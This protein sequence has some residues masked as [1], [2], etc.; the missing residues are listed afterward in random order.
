MGGKTSTSSQQVSVPPQVLAQYQAVNDRA[1]QTASTPFQQYGGE[2]VAPVNDQQNQ[3]IAGTNAAATEAQ[4]YY[5]AATGVLGQAQSDTTGVNQAAIG[6]TASSSSPLTGQQIGQYL[7][8][9]LKTVLGSESALLNQN[10]QQQQAGQLGNAI[11]SGAFGSDRTGIAAANLAQQQE[12]ANA[13]VY[14]G[15]L[16]TGYQSALG[17]AQG[18]QQIGLAGAQQL[19]GI[20]STAYG[21]GA[22]TASELGSLGTG[23]QT[24]GLT[25]AA[26]QIQAGTVQQQTQQAQDTALYN[27]F[28]QKQSYPFQVD[29]FLANI[30]EGTG[31]L[32]GSTTTTQQPG[33]FFSDERLKEDMEPVGKL[34]DGQTIYRYKLKGDS[35]DRIGLSAQETEKTHPEAVG[36]ARG[37]RWVDYGKA[38]DDAANR[39]H[40]YSGGVVGRAPLTERRALAYGG[41]SGGGLDSVLQAQQQMYSGLGARRQQVGGQG[42]G[43][44]QLAVAS[45]SPPPAASGSNTTQQVIGLGKDAYKAYQ[46]FNKPTPTSSTPQA[47]PGVSQTAA[48]AGLQ[49]DTS[50]P[51]GLTT[52]FEMDP[53]AGTTTFYGGDSSGLGA[54]GTGAAGAA[55]TGALDVAG[56]TGA[57]TAAADAAAAGGVDAGVDAGVGAGA[58]G[59]AGAGAGAAA[60]AG[61]GAAAGTAAGAGAADAAAALAAEYAAA[62]VAAAAA[63]AA[64]NGGRIRSKHASGGTPYQGLEGSPYANDSSTEISIPDQQNTESLKTAGPLVKQPT[65]LQTAIKMGDPNQAGSLTGSLFSNQALSTGGVAGRLG[66]ADG[67]TPDDTDAP[68][69]PDPDVAPTNDTGLG[70]AAAG[71]HEASKTGWWS[72]I[73]NSEL[74]KPENLVP[75][76]SAIGA[77]GTAPTRNFGVALAA[78]LGAGAQSYNQTQQALAASHKTEAETQGI[79]IQNQMKQIGLNAARRFATSFQAQQSDATPMQKKNN[80]ALFVDQNVTPENQAQFK[81]SLDN[82]Y[83]NIYGPPEPITASENARQQD[84]IAAQAAGPGMN[85][86]ESQV[87]AG[88]ANRIK[89]QTWQRQQAAQ[90]EYDGLAATYQADPNSPA[91]KLALIKMDRLRQFTGDVTQDI[92]GTYRNSRTGEPVVGAAAQTLNPAQKQAAFNQAMEPVILNNG[93]PGFRYK[94]AGFASPEE[95]VAAQSG[96]A[97]PNQPTSAQPASSPPRTPQ[98]HASAPAPQTAAASTGD[99]YLDKALSDNNYRQ[100]PLPKVV[101]QTTRAAAMK[102]QDLNIANRQKLLA[103]SE[104]A[105][106]ASATALQYLNAA[107]AIMESKGAPV[108]GLYGPIANQISRAFGGIDSTNYQ[109]V[110]KY[111]GNAAAQ[112]A[113]ANFPNATQSEVHMQ[114]NELSPNVSHNDEAIKDLLNTNIRSMKYTA[115]SAKRAKSFVDWGND[116]INFEKWNQSYY[117]R[118]R[119]INT[120]SEGAVPVKSRAEA[121]KL[122]PGTVFI[123]PDGRRLVR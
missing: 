104:Q 48:Q 4:P 112:Q 114:F 101:D 78:G 106:A 105:T 9:Y 30:A 22:N 82:Y 11:T 37:Y 18:Q 43:T 97:A 62:E 23:A 66:Y 79:G 29:E 17:T 15:I 59:A 89:E 25:G 108:T 122:A 120:P 64:K 49:P 13:N 51:S 32:S 71:A 35:R 7:S 8:P 6:Q 67:G 39:S 92:G 87:N 68:V 12:L 60:G 72:K 111:L 65:G 63:V 73:K 44:H 90:H 113:Q 27:Q 28:L 69:T 109:E 98:H 55:D 117:P 83:R 94:Q 10:N 14:S 75:L 95:Y 93:L 88:I 45:G 74:A 46:H 77:M 84:A 58:A 116:P 34:F 26:Q 40:M 123:T 2:F 103:D 115:D 81:S 19:A 110:V 100:A 16:N 53:N 76:L 61:L 31:A 99:P 119:I 57:G 1:Q 85:W 86:A 21:E 91:G 52:N 118:D 38:T 3:G 24:A 56:S 121:M 50:P 41:D 80:A 42:G 33:G 54:A 5:D 70:T 102:Q 96:A 47:G 36:L 20:G 107:K